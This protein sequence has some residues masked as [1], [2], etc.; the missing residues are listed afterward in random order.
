MARRRWIMI[1]ILIALIGVICAAR[2]SIGVIHRSNDRAV[3]Q[4]VFDIP[5]E[6]EPQFSTSTVPSTLGAVTPTPTLPPSAEAPAPTAQAPE[7]T[8][9][10]SLTTA[11]WPSVAATSS[12][13]LQR[14]RS[15]LVTNPMTATP[16]RTVITTSS[17]IAMPPLTPKSTAMPRLATLADALINPFASEAYRRRDERARRDSEYARR[18]D[19]KLN[20]GRINFLLFGYGETHEPPVA[21]DV[22][23][24]SLSIVSYDLRTGR[25]DIVSLT[26]DTRAPEIERFLAQRGK[27]ASPTKIDQA[28]SV[29]GFDL[30]RKTVEDATGLSIDFQIAFKD[31]L[32]LNLVDSVFGAI[33]VDNPAD[34]K[35]QPFYLDGK[36]FEEGRFGKGRQQLNGTQTIQYIKALTAH[37]DASLERNV[38]KVI[39]FRAL[40]DGANQR[41][42]DRDFWLHVSGFVV[43]QSSSR[44]IQYDFDP[45]G[46]LVSHL[47][48]VISNAGRFA[49]GEGCDLGASRIGKSLYVVDPTVGDGGVQWL[50][51]EVLTNPIAKRDLESG[52]YPEAGVGMELPMN[53]NPY[54][55]LIAQY[56]Q[57]VRA[58]VKQSLTLQ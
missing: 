17:P 29:G 51:M 24:G 36:M 44:T 47:P 1:V 28:Y 2:A 58:L 42:H 19:Q 9:V 57:S 11:S 39:V 23:I 10:E 7:S 40:L 20:Q 16:L 26:H 49:K 55:D 32:L 54:G 46:L 8:L 45:L 41:C 13:T 35:V 31:S 5:G 4:P 38:R 6:E 43:G 48:D 34:F 56:W 50:S 30:M 33:E 12:P 37:H 53:S 52:V 25:A 21:V 22:I 27:Q 18:V 15:T 14:P 3:A